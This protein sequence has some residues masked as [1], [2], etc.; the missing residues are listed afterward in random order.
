MVTRPLSA[1]T[2][3]SRPSALGLLLL[4]LLLLGLLPARGLAASALP[5]LSGKPAVIDMADYFSPEEEADFARQLVA[6]SEEYK[7]D[8][9]VVTQLDT[10]GKTNEAYADD[11]FDYSGYGQGTERD[12]ALMLL[13][14]KDIHIST[15]GRTIRYFTDARIRT[16]IDR[17]M[18]PAYQRNDSIVEMTQAYIDASRE[19]LA[20]GIPLG[21]ENVARKENSLS[22]RDIL[23]ALFG[24]LAAGGLFFLANRGR[25]RKRKMKPVYN[26]MALAHPSFGIFHDQVVDRRVT[27]RYIP[28]PSNASS[29]GS[30]GRSSTHTSSSGRT[31]GGGGGSFR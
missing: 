7:M 1:K 12:G 2:Q 11:Y 26:L 31:H 5:E 9:V 15:S 22:L 24:A 10:G 25:Y 17:R 21:Q 29:G 14:E 27:S 30:S 3:P 13:T 16:I 4:M 18:I 8:F 19:F 23:I 6:L 28:P 20:A